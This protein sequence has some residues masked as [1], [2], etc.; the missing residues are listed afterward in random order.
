MRAVGGG[1]FIGG[2][3]ADL[4]KGQRQRRL[5]VGL[6]ES[7]GDTAGRAVALARPARLGWAL[8]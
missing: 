4:G 5:G 7:G 6:P 1:V 3:S 8:A 2:G